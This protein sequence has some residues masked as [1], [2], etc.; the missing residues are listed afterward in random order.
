MYCW[1]EATTALPEGFES[2]LNSQA[3]VDKSTTSAESD[4]VTIARAEHELAMGS[5]HSVIIRSRRGG[6]FDL[7]LLSRS[8]SSTQ[9]ASNRRRDRSVSSDL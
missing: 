3:P 7:R 6:R 4:L 8:R 5:D 1:P 2:S 9:R